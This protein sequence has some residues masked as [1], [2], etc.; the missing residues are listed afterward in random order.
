MLMQMAE[1]TISEKGA[2]ASLAESGGLSNL[3]SAAK[4]F[5]G[6]HQL[7]DDR[8]LEGPVA[9]AAMLRRVMQVEG[10]PKQVEK[11]VSAM[12]K[13]LEKQL[14]HRGGE[15]WWLGD[16]MVQDALADSKKTAA[17][18]HVPVD[19]V[20]VDVVHAG[21][22]A[23]RQWQLRT[24]LT[25]AVLSQ[26]LAFMVG[27]RSGESCLSGESHGI[28]ATGIFFTAMWC[29]VKLDDFKLNVLGAVLSVVAVSESGFRF[30]DALIDYAREWGMHITGGTFKGEKVRI[31]DYYVVRI[32]LQ[33]M[34]PASKAGAAFLDAL[35]DT[36]VWL[37][38]MKGYDRVLRDYYPRRARARCAHKNER[39]RFVNVW[40]GKEAEVTAAAS[41]FRR[42]LLASYQQKL[43]VIG[44]ADIQLSALLAA[45]ER[46][47]SV[48]AGPLMR[49][50]YHGRLTHMP[51]SRAE[52][53]ADTGTV[54][55]K[56]AVTLY[57]NDHGLRLVD[58][59]GR[60]GGCAH[61]R[62]KAMEAGWDSTLLREL[63]NAHFRW[64]PEHDRMQVYYTG[65]LERTQRLRVTG[66]M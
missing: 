54:W 17:P 2:S 6:A 49:S 13:L 50:M 15:G 25:R 33:G 45:A 57:G 47:V 21:I 7:P 60:H 62:R 46:S 16:N 22:A 4:R 28:L 27:F 40:G 53:H 43:D 19:G 8:A 29:D 65:L 11:H 59:S 9:F 3:R 34:A 35:G 64:A 48:T 24:A 26:L 1:L 44:V 51:Q 38:N 58:H 66:I 61:A 12:G 20:Q 14:G 18:A 36:T 42:R 5:G 31:I 23:T 52:F 41:E 30:V 56:E 32:S 10:H 37:S 63:V 39:A 55:R